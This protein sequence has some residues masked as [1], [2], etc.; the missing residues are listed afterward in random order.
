MTNWEGAAPPEQTAGL[1]AAIRRQVQPGVFRYSFVFD[2]LEI[3]DPAL[4]VRGQL[5]VS[6]REYGFVIRGFEGG[7]TAWARDFSNGT[8]LVVNAEGS[9]HVLSPKVPARILFVDPGGSVL[10][11]TGAS[12]PTPVSAPVPVSRRVTVR[13]TVNATVDLQGESADMARSVLIRVVDRAL[14]EGPEPGET[15]VH[16]VEHSFEQSAVL[17]TEASGSSDTDFSQLLGI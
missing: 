4:D 6:P 15:P 3:D 9:S 2:E 8:L 7:R 12:L 13:L 5:F 17:A 14:R 10:Q 11:D 1:S 16:I